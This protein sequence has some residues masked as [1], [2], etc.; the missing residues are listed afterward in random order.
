[1]INAAEQVKARGAHLIAIVDD[2]L[3][4]PTSLQVDDQIVV[5]FNGPLTA[6]MCAIPLQLIAYELAVARLVKAFQSTGEHALYFS[7]FSVCQRY[8]S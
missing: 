7:L 2:P 4:L 8:Q 5:P 1:M 6:L 3:T